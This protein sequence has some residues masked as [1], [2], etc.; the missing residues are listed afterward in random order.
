MIK[1][2][3]GVGADR[4]GA[5]R[6]AIF[7]VRKGGRVSIPASTAACPTSSRPAP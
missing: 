4:I 1:Q 6:Q 5:L 3:V 2:K 7:A